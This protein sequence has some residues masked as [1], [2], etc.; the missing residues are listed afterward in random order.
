[1]LGS[2][3]QAFDALADFARAWVTTT[4]KRPHFCPKDVY[5]HFFTPKIAVDAAICKKSKADACDDLKPYVIG[6]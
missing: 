3:P 6:A 2:P 1:L 5:L 4:G